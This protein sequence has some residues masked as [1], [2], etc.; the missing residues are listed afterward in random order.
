MKTKK[1]KR[2]AKHKRVRVKI[3]GTAEKPRLAVFRSNSH[4]YLQAIDDE[5]GKT[6]VSLS[7][8]KIKKDYKTLIKENKITKKTD[9]A[10]VIG[11][12]IAKILKEKNISQAVF[13]RGGFKYHGIVKA[14]AEGAREGGLKL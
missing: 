1:E 12:E 2:I 6:L 4:I 14:V 11:K 3:L 8:I 9:L 10:S 5:Y 13:D 7:D